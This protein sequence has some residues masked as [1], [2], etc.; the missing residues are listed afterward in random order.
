MDYKYK[1]VIEV[2]DQI[3]FVHESLSKGGYIIID[4][5]NSYVGVWNIDVETSITREE[6]PYCMH[7]DQEY[8]SSVLGRVTL[9]RMVAELLK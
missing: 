5:W 1:G 8:V 2:P 9:K 6:L 4:I 7:E 3:I